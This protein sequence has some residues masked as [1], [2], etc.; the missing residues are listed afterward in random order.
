MAVEVVLLVLGQVSREVVPGFRGNGLAE[1]RNSCGAAGQ[2]LPRPWRILDGGLRVLDRHGDL[3][4]FVQVERLQ[5]REYAVGVP[6][7]DVDN[8]PD[9]FR[10]A[11][12]PRPARCRPGFRRCVRRAFR[13][14]VDARL[15]RPIRRR[16]LVAALGGRSHVL[17]LALVRKE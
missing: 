8:H 10:P 16:R 1:L 17:S 11:C 3:R 13:P 6:G 12:S 15:Q 9:P 5:G 4:A 14:V 2:A 7:F